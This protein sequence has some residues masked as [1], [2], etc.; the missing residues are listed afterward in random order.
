MREISERKWQVATEEIV[1]QIEGGES[2]EGA[3]ARRYG[4][5]EMV[6][7]EVEA[8]DRRKGR[9]IEGVKLT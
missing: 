7:L 4:T 3:D 6:A 5:E 1:R 8:G 9:E 2:R